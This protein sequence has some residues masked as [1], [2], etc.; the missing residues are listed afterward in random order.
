[1]SIFSRFLTLTGIPCIFPF[2]HGVD[3]ETPPHVRHLYKWS[4]PAK[5]E[6]D[7]DF[8]L[9]YF[10]PISLEE[11]LSLSEQNSSTK[12][13]FHL[14]FDDGLK[15]CYDIIFPLLRKKG[16]PATFFLNSAFLGNKNLF[17]RYKVSIIIDH[18]QG[19][20]YSPYLLKDIA[21]LLGLASITQQSLP[22]ELKQVSYSQRHLLDEIADLIGAS[23]SDYLKKEQPYM[24]ESQ[25]QEL[26]KAGFS[27]G[28][29]SVDHPMYAKI[30]PAS[31]VQ[32]SLESISYVN[33]TFG[34]PYK[35]FA[36]PFTDQGVP[37]E[38]FEHLFNAGIH[39]SFGTAGLKKDEFPLHFQRIPMEKWPY[40]ANHILAKEAGLYIPKL[41][42]GKNKVRRN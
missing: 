24:N 2:Y 36:F 9:T 40:N 8:F 41:F 29:H 5:F 28:G 35:A 38:V 32:Q 37:K 33:N 23:L 31:Q 17:Y 3:F 22:T 34:V 39:C 10:S 14:S 7:L 20:P 26:V 18:I 42:V 27:V 1:M 16:I 30:S 19:K 15:S 6:R 11:L 13:F 12:P 25:V 4:T 21:E